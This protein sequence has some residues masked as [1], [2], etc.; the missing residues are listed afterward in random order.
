[1][2]IGSADCPRYQKVFHA[3]FTGPKTTF[4]LMHL[5]NDCA[6]S[7]TIN[8]MKRAGYPIAPAEY[9]GKNENGRKVYLYRLEGQL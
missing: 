8:E 4:Q 9:R 5:T 1:M 7:T 3:L 6:V 2:N